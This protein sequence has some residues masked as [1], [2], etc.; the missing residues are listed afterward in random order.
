MTRKLNPFLTKLY[1]LNVHQLE[2]VS[3]YLDPPLHVDE[4]Y[5]YLPNLRQHI[6]KL[7]CLN[8][9]FIPNNSD[10]IG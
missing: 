6:C 8:N 10:F 9:N 4:N 2:A 7:W 1:Y 5:S 3:R